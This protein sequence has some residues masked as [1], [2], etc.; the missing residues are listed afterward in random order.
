MRRITITNSSRARRA[1]E[2]TSYAEVVLGSAAAD[3]LHPAFSNLFVQ[4]EIIRDKRTIL[5]TRRPR[6]PEEQPPWMF[7]LMAVHGAKIEEISYETDRMRFIGRGRTIANPQAMTD[8]TPLSGREGSVLDPIVAIRHKIV[9]NPEEKVTIDIVSGIG[10]TRDACLG[11]AEKYQDRRLADRVF[12]LAWTHSQVLLRQINA[13]EA[14]AQLYGHLAGS[15]VLRQFLVPR[16]RR[17]SS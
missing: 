13:T 9:L 17:A 11:L 10:E 14:D 8:H 16:G 5:C 6:S 15:I 12:G 1:I 3:A 4:T 2:V 7:H